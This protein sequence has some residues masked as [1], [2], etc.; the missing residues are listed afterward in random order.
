MFCLFFFVFLTS[1]DFPF[2]S[3]VAFVL[4]SLVSW[5]PEG[6]CTIGSV[7]GYIPSHTYADRCLE[8]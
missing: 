6:V 8:S 3:V 1:R 4:A 7:T 2:D 5:L